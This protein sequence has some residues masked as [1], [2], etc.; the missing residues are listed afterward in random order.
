MMQKKDKNN[1]TKLTSSKINQ[2]ELVRISGKLISS[3]I[4]DSIG[5]RNELD[6]VSSS[7]FLLVM[8]DKLI[9][10]RINLLKDRID[11][12]L[13][14]LQNLKLTFV[15]IPF[16]TR[17]VLEIK[18]CTNQINVLLQDVV[19]KK[20]SMQSYFVDTNGNLVT[21]FFDNSNE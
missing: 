1:I 6:K 7:S 13:K 9:N 12:Y 2:D 11:T 20:N 16:S 8:N 18:E 15:T 5:I 3:I 19:D 10:A 4:R 14:I 21:T 17:F